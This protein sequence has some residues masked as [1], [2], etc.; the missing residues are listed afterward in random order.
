MDTSPTRLV[1]ARR[2]YSTPMLLRREAFP[3]FCEPCLPS[4]PCAARSVR[5]ANLVRQ[6]RSGR[7]RRETRARHAG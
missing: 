4:P 7:R 5:A 3:D 6:V 2:V 1:R